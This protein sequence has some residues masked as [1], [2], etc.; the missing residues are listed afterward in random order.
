MI[1]IFIYN[2]ESTHAH[3]HAFTNGFLLIL[4]DIKLEQHSDFAAVTFV[5]WFKSW[6]ISQVCNSSFCFEQTH[7]IKDKWRVYFQNEYLKKY[8]FYYVIMF[9][10]CKLA[11]VLQFHWYE[12]ILIHFGTKLFM[13]FLKGFLKY[14]WSLSL[15]RPTLLAFIKK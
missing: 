14:I 2:T 1:I 12:F 7:E 8:V 6:E 13:D 15:S 11:V 3:Y 4:K 9:L 5:Q 10:S